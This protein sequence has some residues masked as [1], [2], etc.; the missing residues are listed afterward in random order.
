MKKISIIIIVYKIAQYLQQCLDSVVAQTY[1]NLEIILVLGHGRDTDDGCERICQDMAAGDSRIKIID[2]KAAGVSDARNRGLRAATGELIGFVDGDD[3]IDRDMFEHLVR[4]MD[5]KDTDISVCGRY[6]TFQN[7]E[8]ADRAY[9]DGPRVMDDSQALEMILNGNGFYLHCWDKLYKKQLWQ[10]IEFPIDSYVED[11]IV[12]NRILARANKIVYDPTPKYHY[13]ERLGSMSKTGSIAR[14]NMEANRIL[15]D[16]INKEYP[17]LKTI[18]DTYLVYEYI[19][20]IQNVYLEAD[21]RGERPDK[22]EIFEYKRE[23]KGLYETCSVNLGR[24]LRLKTVLALKWPYILAL[25][26]RIKNKKIKTDLI[27]FQ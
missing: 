1:E 13:R 19:T 27:R 9:V 24:G 2:C 16:F 4:L 8:N 3:Y 25:N 12:V 18:C 20:A 15:C 5:E 26:T 21:K 23:L 10:D 11:R 6:Y 7:T 17:R 22:T 14:Q